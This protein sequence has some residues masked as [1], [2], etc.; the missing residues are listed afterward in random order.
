MIIYIDE[1]MSPYIARG[2][3]VLQ[4]PLNLDLPEEIEIRT[5]KDDFGQGVQDEDWIPK[6][7]SNG[8]CV[9]TQDYNIKRIRHQQKLCEEYA[10]GIFYFRPPSKNGFSYFD[11]VKLMVK[12]WMEINKISVREKRP[13]AYKVTSKGKLEKLN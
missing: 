11:M 12:H 9:I 10:L 1:N 8:A 7:G 13:F 4:K 2:F 5:I 3:D 6:A